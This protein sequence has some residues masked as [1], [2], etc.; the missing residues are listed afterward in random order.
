MLLYKEGNFMQFLE[1]AE[2]NVRRI[3]AKIS[4]DPRHTGLIKFLEGFEEERQFPE[5]SMGFR[6]LNRT[7]EISETGYNE[8]M[9]TSFTG[10][11]F[12]VNPT[13]AQRLLLSFKRIM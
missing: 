9:N 4:A 13:R 2:D 12:A 6:D 10:K 3:Y 1:G 8:I 5:W 7:G 11:E